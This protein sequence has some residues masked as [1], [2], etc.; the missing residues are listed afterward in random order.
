MKIKKQE[1]H[2]SVPWNE[3]INFRTII[4][5]KASQTGNIIQFLE[6]KGIDAYCLTE[7]KKDFIKIGK[8]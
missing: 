8:Y 5:L 7:T 2:K 6:K 1:V 3:T 4:Y